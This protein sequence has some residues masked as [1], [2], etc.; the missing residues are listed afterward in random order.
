[1]ALVKIEPYIIDDVAN[2]TFGGLTITSNA[3]FGNTNLG[4]LATANFLTVSGDANL[5]NA[6][7][8]NYFIGNGSLL[9]G[10]TT[11]SLVNGTSNIVV[12]S[13]GNAT[14]SIG[15]T[16]NVVTI[17]TTGTNVNGYI[18]ATQF[19]GEAGN[20]SNIQGANVSGTV[21][22]A[23]T[24]GTV[25]T[26]AQ[27]NITS[28]GLLANLSVNG[29][30]SFIGNANIVGNINQSA[31]T[32]NA[33]NLSVTGN[34][35]ISGANIS[36]GDVSNLH[37]TGGNANYVLKTDGTG[38]LSWT[39]MTGGSGATTPGDVVV[40][41]FTG[42]GANTS[43]T[44]SITPDDVKYVIVNIDGVF[45]FRQ[46]YAL[47]GNVLT[48]GSAPVADSL[49]EISTTVPG[50]ILGS[51]SNVDFGNISS[52]IIPTSNITY[53]LGT[54]TK[55]WKD[56]YLSNSTIHLGDTAFSADANGNIILGN[57][58]LDSNLGNVTTSQF[59]PFNLTIAPEVLTINADAPFAGNDIKWLFS[60]QQSTLPYSRATIV[61]QEQIS[62]PLYKQGTYQ[63]NN[64][65]NE[66]H[67]NMTQMHKLYLKWVDG[68][69]TDNNV[70]WAVNAGN[71]SFSDANING[72]NTTIVQR[73]NIT[74]PSNITLPTLTLPAN[75]YY[76]V[77]ATTSNVYSFTGMG[78]GDNRTIG[79]LYR[80]ATYTFN[81]DSSLGN[82]NKFYLTTDNGTAFVAGQYIGEYTSGVTGSR[83]NGAAGYNTL[84]FVVP[85][86]AP[87]VLYYQSANVA[88]RHGAIVIKD[89]A[90]ET[91]VNGNYVLYFQHMKEGH[92]TP[93]EIRPIPSMVNQMC[94]VYDQ[95]VGKF[96]PQDMATYVENTPSF[97][98][99]IREVAG[100]ATLIAPN[101]VAVVPTVLV[102]EDTSYLPLVNNKDGDI[103]FDSYYETMYVWDTNAWKSTKPNLS[104]YATQTYVSNSIAN[105]VNS[106]PAALDTLNELATALGNDASYSTTITNALA[107]KLSTT[108]FTSTA[109]TWLATKTLTASSATTAATVTTNAQPNITSVGTLTGLN[110]NGNITVTGNI[111]PSSNVT[112]NLGSPTNRF[113]DIFLSGNTID[114]AGA[115]I[116]TDA[117]TGAIA[118]VPQPTANVPNPTA[119]VISPTGAVSTAATTGGNI[120]ANTLANAVSNSAVIASYGTISVSQP[121][122]ITAP[123]TG[124]ARCY[125]TS[126]VNIVNIFASLGTPSSSNLQF[127]LK[128]NGSNV[129]NGTVTGNSYRMTPISANISV[130]TTDY[131][132]LD[133][134]AGSG[135]TDL[136]VD[137]QYKLQ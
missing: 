115:T 106:A 77:A 80:G 16:S 63:V 89:L 131:L 44:L 55:R 96:V 18:S 8:A 43:F 64:F 23:N 2:Y 4:N 102:V 19:V 95:T 109:D 98:N 133:I 107:N 132:T 128:K 10:I 74:V 73:L 22:A 118:L 97:K 5:G 136:K 114:L 79:P 76:N 104:A 59:L 129:A 1:M 99:K 28:V 31:G 120:S 72:G 92:K 127:T 34:V 134:T 61:N 124:V 17:T 21:S 54:P 35:T 46:S 103:A 113:K 26:A 90:V 52:N 57:I 84:T 119:L 25:T 111:T 126:N 11:T 68:P 29:N 27:P 105:L 110:V 65:A 56:L 38:N 81:L 100:T 50:T 93:V 7:S 48:F 122:N 53:D 42:D 125:P 12:S 49:I 86:D 108:S 20:L 117:T 45:Q 24:A 101:G 62:V 75:I 123:F 71:V 32:V 37:I 30:S 51:G 39:E 94:L 6:A 9:T 36:L 69:G 82:D 87:D 47:S 66:V 14:F 83:G 137:L 67:G 88:A 78:I 70:S 130:S 135:A 41:N 13:N 116:K 60:W 33:S 15:G 58:T 40:D 112:Y 3:V 85:N 91:N 121:G